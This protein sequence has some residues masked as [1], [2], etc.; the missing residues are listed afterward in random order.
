[1]ATLHPTRPIRAALNEGERATDATAAAVAAI[2]TRH[3]G[4]ELLL[5]HGSR[6]RSEAHPRSDWDLAYLADQRFDPSALCAD[7]VL[8]LGT[9]RIDLVDLNGAS[10]LLRY[11]AARDAVV[12]HQAPD[13]FEKFWHQAVTF[14]C[15]AEPLL[16][17][18]YAE[19][20]AGLDR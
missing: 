12:L 9:D 16:R 6:A 14:W 15:D 2:A 8:D 18:G 17:R 5:L 20:L 3:P 4:L 7:L 19:I 11:R 1:M 10:G 13:A